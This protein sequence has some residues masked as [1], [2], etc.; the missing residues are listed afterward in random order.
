MIQ[1]DIP[2][3]ENC[4]RCPCYGLNEFENSCNITGHIFTHN[5]FDGRAE[6]CP[7]EEQE[8]VE[9]LAQVDDTYKCRCGAVVGWDELESS[10]I[11]KTRLNYCPFCGKRVKWDDN[12]GI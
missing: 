7:L 12:V 2:M 8:P 1:I 11:V 4:A 9:P 3:P 6:D 5:I 10:G